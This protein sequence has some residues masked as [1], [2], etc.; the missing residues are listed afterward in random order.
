MPPD[1]AI[2]DPAAVQRLIAAVG[3]RRWLEQIAWAI[4]A[5]TAAAAV[6][7]VVAHLTGA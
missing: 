4:A 1:T 3:R 5:G 7:V 6:L 2:G